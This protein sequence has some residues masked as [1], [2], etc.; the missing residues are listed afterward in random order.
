[1]MLPREHGAYGQLLF[2]MLTALAIGRPSA[3]AWLTAA[4][5]VAVFAAH[6]PALVM[7]GRRGAALRRARRREAMTWLLAF[8]AAA[9]AFGTLALVSL[10]IANRWTLAVPIVAGVVAAAYVA[11]GRERTTDGEIVVAAALASVSFPVAVA[12]SASTTVALTCALAYTAVFIAA[13][14]SVRAVIS[15]AQRRTGPYRVVA[16]GM[17]VVV[18]ATIAMLASQ[19]VIL[20]AGVAA[21]LPMCAIALALVW[22]LPPARYLRRIGWT[23]VGATALTGLILIATIR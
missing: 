19:R 6:E 20:P 7:L 11:Q 13:T 16:F 23:L 3:A 17:A 1:M 14:V 18:L 2:P 4:A 12:S 9:I 15:A 10:P 22:L 8:G 5:A 21:A